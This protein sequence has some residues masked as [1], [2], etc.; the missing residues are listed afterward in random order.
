MT[1]GERYGHR[2]VHFI[3]GVIEVIF[4]SIDEEPYAVFSEQ[5]EPLGILKIVTTPTVSIGYYDRVEFLRRS[6]P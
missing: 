5:L 2:D 4:R 6:I 1:L 3:V